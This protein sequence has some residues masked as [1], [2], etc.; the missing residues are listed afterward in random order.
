MKKLLAFALALGLTCAPLRAMRAEGQPETLT[1]YTEL[2]PCAEVC[3][4]ELLDE[5][6]Q[7]KAAE[8]LSLHF[9]H[10]Y[11]YSGDWH[12]QLWNH[13]RVILTEPHVFMA[14]TDEHGMTTVYCFATIDSYALLRG[15]DGA[16]YFT[17]HLDTEGFY[18]VCLF[19]DDIASVTWMGDTEDDELYPGA[20]YADEGYPGWSDEL[21][22]QIPD[23]C[24]STAHIAQRYLDLNGIDATVIGR[25]DRS[26]AIP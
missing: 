11:P 14:E 16:L 24:W 18:R 19:G 6:F 21:E 3:F 20:G 15:D 10:L 26:P 25:Y 23:P 4:D 7:A 17:Q 13:T 12:H 22:R 5:P 8:A 2:L 1:A 9:I